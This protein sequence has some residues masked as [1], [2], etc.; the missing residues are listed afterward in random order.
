MVRTAMGADGLETRYELLNIATDDAKAV[1]RRLDFH[2]RRLHPDA[3]LLELAKVRGW[4]QLEQALLS[5]VADLDEDLSLCVCP[6]PLSEVAL[7]LALG[8]RP[9]CFVPSLSALRSLRWRRQLRFP[10][11]E[12]RPGQWCEFVT[13]FEKERPEEVAALRA[14]VS[15]GSDLARRLGLSHSAALGVDAT[16]ERLLADLAKCDLLRIAC[17]G[18]IV[19]HAESVD[20]VVAAD[21]YLA[22]SNLT[23]ILNSDVHVLGWRQLAD[24]TSAP[25]VVISSACDS[26]LNVKN[27]ARERLGLE[28]P[29]FFA[30]MIIYVAP[31]WPVPIRTIQQVVSELMEAWLQA[32]SLSLAVHLSRLRRRHLAAGVPHLASRALAV[33]GD[34]L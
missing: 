10:T 28:R 3:Q 20:L 1:V 31:L 24:L 5:T 2:L 30:G 4:G 8:G 26:G 13:W 27:E 19:E 7:S 11:L 22:P 15:K 17:H 12:V 14:S 34:G 6:G 32:P 29:L 25:A 21:G 33:F 18:R 9:L 23:S 16:A